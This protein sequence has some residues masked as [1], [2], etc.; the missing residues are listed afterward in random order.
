M[1]SAANVI[2]VYVFIT[3]RGYNY[4]A[5]VNTV[6]V[7]HMKRNNKAIT[8]IYLVLCALIVLALSLIA[9]N[10][11]SVHQYQVKVLILTMTKNEES[12]WLTHEKLHF[13][14]YVP[15]AYG[16]VFCNKLGL[17]VTEIGESKV[18]ASESVT[19]IL[20][21]KQFI[22]QHTYFIT[23]GIAGTSPSTG[24]L[25]FVALARWIVDWDQ[26]SHL[27]PDTAA[28]VPFG[29]VPNTTAE[30]T[31]FHLNDRLTDL[32]YVIT[33]QV[34][35]KD[36]SAA[37]SMR[38]KYPGQAGKRPFVAL[39]DTI[40]GDDFWAGKVLS[41][42]AQYI[43]HTATNHYGNYCTTEQEDSAVAAVL[44]HFG[45]LGRY[46][47]VRAASNFDQPYAGQSIKELFSQFPARDIANQN[48]YL[49]A[50]TIAR[51][52]IDHTY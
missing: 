36:S 47:N 22:F 43:I 48:V 40:A 16:N 15:G 28:G 42:E 12:L 7:E 37:W 11:I 30:N 49:I 46:I 41:D 3:E 34:K 25:G 31:V 51:Y 13:V 14:Y 44:Q 50:A 35:L 4:R 10:I 5:A 33:T 9:F 6:L 1:I 32:A 24:T 27:L 19:A 38:Q 20:L 39:C 29:Y 26:G 18:N 52:F 21:N 17:C 2:Y 23:A 45:Y 8:G